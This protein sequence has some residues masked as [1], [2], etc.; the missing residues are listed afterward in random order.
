[1]LR[2]RS[3]KDIRSKSGTVEGAIGVSTTGQRFGEE[4]E[5]LVGMVQWA[6]TEATALAFGSWPGIFAQ[7]E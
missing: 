5:C 2:P 7:I 3:H 4:A 6:A 1:M